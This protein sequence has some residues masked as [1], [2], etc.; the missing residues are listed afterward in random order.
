M[1]VAV[2][3]PW[4]D[5]GPERARAHDLVTAHWERILPGARLVDI[6]TTH[7]P[8]CLAACRNA[9]VAWAERHHVDVVVLADADTLA[10]AEPVGAAVHAAARSHVVQLPYTE[11]RSLR[12]DGTA[13]YLA[14][15]P[16]PDCNAFVVPGACSG[17]YITTPAT[18]WAHGGQDERFR[19]WGFEDA[20]WHTAHT[21]LLG[22]DPARHPGRVYSLTHPSA[23]KEGEQYTANAALCHR[24]HRAAADPDAMR[25]LIAEAHTPEH[26]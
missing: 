13:Q 24:Y 16:L 25:A 5:T 26:A 6:D 8:F 2:V 10:E 7:E 22:A 18:W 14:G 19:G 15:V 17:V 20:A 21:T 1:S 12:G 4:R 3:L 11:Y 23:V 9:G